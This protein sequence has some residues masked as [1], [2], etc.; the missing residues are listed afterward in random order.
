MKKISL[1]ILCILLLPIMVNAKTRFL[2][3]VIKDE[4]ESNGLA[5]EFAGEHQDNIDPSLSKYKIYHWYAENND[6]GEEILNK[7]NVIFGDHC[8]QMFRTTDTGGVKI[9]YN[10]EAENNKCLNTRGKH[11]GYIQYQEKQTL[12]SN[13]YYGSD[14]SYNKETNLFSLSGDL[15]QVTWN[16]SIGSSLNGKYT[17]KQTTQDGTCSKLYF[18]VS[19]ATAT[20]A[21]VIPMDGNRSY[22]EFGE[23]ALQANAAS[24]AG[25][26]YMYGDPSPIKT[27][28]SVLEQN[29]TTR[30]TIIQNVSINNNHWFADSYDY[31]QNQSDPFTLNE[32]YKVT[33]EEYP[34]LVEK[35]T[36]RNA[37]AT[38][39]YHS[40][41]YIAAVSGNTSYYRTIT[42]P[43]NLEEATK[44]AFADSISENGDG[45]YSLNSPQ[46]VMYKD[47]FTNYEN[48]KNKYTCG[49]N[50]LTC[51]QPHYITSTQNNNYTYLT[52]NSGTKILIA[53]QRDGLNLIDTIAVDPALLV[54]N[55]DDYAEYN[56]TCNNN[57]N[58][59]EES[60]LR[61]IH[62][63]TEVGYKY[64]PNY[65]FAN[66]VTW[67]NDHYKLNDTIDLESYKDLNQIKN[68]HYI[69]TE[70]GKKECTSVAYIH[71][72]TSV[73][74]KYYYDEISNGISGIEEALN[75]MWTKNNYESLLK[76]G[77]DA[78]YEK[79][80]INYSDYLEDTLFC[81]DRRVRNYNGWDPNKATNSYI[82]FKGSGSSSTWDLICPNEAD[83][84]QVANPKA[85]LKYP[86][87]VATVPELNL[88][89][90]DLVRTTGNYYWLMTPC[91][92]N[93]L[94]GRGMSINPSG[95]FS[96][97]YNSTHAMG[98]RPVVSLTPKTR[99][100][101]GTG[102]ME[103]PYIVDY[104]MYYNIDVE[105]RNETKDF[106]ISIEDL[107]SV[108]EGE[109][110]LFKVTPIKGYKITG[111]EI[112]DSN[113]NVITSSETSNKNE[114]TFIMP[115]SDVTIIPSYERVS[116]SVTVE[117]NS[118]TKEIKV[119][120]N[121][122]TA[123]VYED[124]VVFTVEPEE[125]YEVENII[126]KDE[127]NNK[128]KYQKLN[129]NKY[130]FIMPDTNVVITPVYKRIE[131]KDIV[132]PKTHSIFY[133]V[134]IISLALWL[135]L[136]ISKIKKRVN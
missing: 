81:N 15:T 103:D 77:I 25:A 98:V 39:K 70:Y 3:D 74:A 7:N 6:Q 110:V 80:L 37:N 123:V 75:I 127:N 83:Q 84:F 76:T 63:I 89:N 111:I 32:P 119:E 24:A 118:N 4:A 50:T 65:Y 53:K 56:Y 125:G 13:Y 17:C 33:P 67:E 11:I 22:Y 41:F 36:L 114:Y 45:T 31:D 131:N 10:G 28:A 82:Y 86:I 61:N 1:L 12:T 95:G 93:E 115:E 134:I 130:E 96:T 136:L 100:A 20:Q 87:A 40:V 73:G 106:D 23:L 99:F 48:Y 102:S 19:Y 55:K 66:S 43:Q 132:N 97:Y 113:N 29:F 21:N 117:E 68:H 124:R 105:I 79:Y 135:G 46:L 34:N 78:W 107:T 72:Y 112:I 27:V 92:V 122:A 38:A 49:D 42:N 120:V 116:N 16:E 91:W 71:N 47:Y 129:E 2:Y 18:I 64:A 59:C 57:S 52:I 69:C 104:N 109:E 51:T 30:R 54:L 44:I 14:Y 5:R 94:Y 8:W 128:I 62:S 133:A 108:S 88:L 85:K 58:V 26:G 101:S 35:Y 60:T 121:D 126:I 90:N 9:I